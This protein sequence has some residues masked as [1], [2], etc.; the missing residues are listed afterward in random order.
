MIPFDSAPSEKWLSVARRRGESP[1]LE[2]AKN[3]RRSLCHSTVFDFPTLLFDHAVRLP[4]RL[5]D[6][7]ARLCRLALSFDSVVRLPDFAG[8]VFRA[9]SRPIAPFDYVVR[10]S[11]FTVRLCRPASRSISP[12]DLAVRLCRATLPFGFPILPSD[13]SA[14]LCRSARPCDCFRLFNFAVRLCGL[15]SN[16]SL[17]LSICRSTCR[18]CGLTSNF[19]ISPNLSLDF[20]VRLSDFAV[21]PPD[22]PTMLLFLQT[23]QGQSRCSQ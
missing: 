7:A 17:D 11:D 10:L 5:F 21:R 23:G 4:V 2:D 22:S 19:S 14:R 15:T 20:A 6:F 9:T 18:L 8:R 16:L 13:F 1:P 12:F 3:L